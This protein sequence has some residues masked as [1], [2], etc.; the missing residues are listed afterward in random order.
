MPPM[1]PYA[2]IFV[3]GAKVAISA[4]GDVK[5]RRH[6]APSRY[7]EQTRIGRMREYAPVRYALRPASPLTHEN[8]QNVQ[9][10]R[11]L[12]K[13]RHFRPVRA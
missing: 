1:S 7:A 8:V 10:V 4:L 9:N 6:F 11:K 3:L 12:Q 13:H 5:R 2:F